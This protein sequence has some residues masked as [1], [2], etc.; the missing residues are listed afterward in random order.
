MSPTCWIR[1]PNVNVEFGAREA[2]LGRQRRRTREFF[3]KYQDRIMFGTDNGIE[4]AMYRNHFRWLEAG[5]DTSIIGATRTRPLE[6]LWSGIAGLSFGEGVSQKRR[7]HF[8]AIQSRQR[9]ED[10]DKRE[11]ALHTSAQLAT[12]RLYFWRA[13]CNRLPRKW[14]SV[15]RIE[16]TLFSS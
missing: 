14:Y 12:N 10:R 5:D 9:S 8:Q 1:F 7:T 11:L 13:C 3:I 15:F 2:E 4:G 16:L 6:K